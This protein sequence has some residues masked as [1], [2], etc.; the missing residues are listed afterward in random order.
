MKLFNIE[1]EALTIAKG[2]IT[3][4]EIMQQPE[5]W[6]E[7]V[8]ILGNNKTPIQIFLNKALAEKNVRVIITGAGTSAYVGDIVAPYLRRILGLR[9]ES[10]ATTDLVANPED[11]FEKNTPTI[12]VSCA[13][14]GNSPESVA[15]YNLA[16]QLID[17]LY[18]VIITCDKDGNLAQEVKGKEKNLLILMPEASNDSGFAMTGSFSC[19]VITLLMMFD[20]K[21]FKENQVVVQ[22]IIECG[23][24]I[25]QNE[26]K[27]LQTI[28]E[29]GYHRIVYLGSS[30][31]RG[32]AKEAAL[33]TLELSSGKVAAL[34]ESILGFR[35]GP[36]SIVDDQTVVFIFLSN[37]SY[38][39]QYDMDLL[40]ELYQEKG[41]YKIVVISYGPDKKIADLADYTL[42]VNKEA[43]GNREDA[44]AGMA[45]I[46]YAQIYAFLNSLALG[47]TPDNPRADG[48]VNRVV[49]G[50]S[51]YSYDK[52][53]EK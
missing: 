28:L 22:E 42:I 37:Q 17:T 36:K 3:A 39:R 12:L 41:Q 9:I 32:L 31:L 53:K 1:Q 11:F 16:E 8:D 34:S 6:K 27:Y 23:K 7:T 47:I 18:H 48:T 13:R 24:N 49:K 21:H 40:K 38:T 30:V 51:I 50:V 10:I 5:L 45:Y 2:D 4:L 52:C 44:Y 29:N 33:K 43:I 25:L 46:L 35:H 20:L 15:T 19:M 14:S 26:A